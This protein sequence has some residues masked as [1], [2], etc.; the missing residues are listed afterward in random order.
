MM[1]SKQVPNLTVMTIS[2][3]RAQFTKLHKSMEGMDVVAVTKYGRPRLAIVPW[4][5]YLDMLD[6]VNQPQ[7]P[8]EPKREHEQER[9]GE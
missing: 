7:P 2:E 4:Y 8:T 5:S 6:Q 1:S 9:G 3:A